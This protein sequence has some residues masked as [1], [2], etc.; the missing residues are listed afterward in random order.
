MAEGRPPEVVGVGAGSG[1]LFVKHLM[2]WAVFAV[3]ACTFVMVTGGVAPAGATALA[4][5]G[6]TD[7]PVVN[8][9]RIPA[10]LPPHTRHIRG[11]TNVSATNWSGYA[12]VSSTPGT[13]TAVTD[14]F[15][16]P[17]VVPPASGKQYVADW[18]G[19][20]GYSDTTLVQTGIQAFVQ[21]RKHHSTVSYDAWT[22]Y[23]PKPEDPL[24]LV[25]SAGDTVTATVQETSADSWL[26][27]VDDVTTGNSAQRPVLSYHS[28]GESAE[29][30]NE[31]PCIKA[32]CLPRDLAHLA[33]TQSPVTFGP[34]FYSTAPPGPGPIV[35]PLALLQPTGSL[36]LVDIVMTNNQEY[37]VH[38]H[39]LGALVDGRRLRRGRRGRPPDASVHLIAVR[40][41]H[42][43]AGVSAGQKQF[44]TGGISRKEAR[45]GGPG[46]SSSCR[47]SMEPWSGP[48]VRAC[49]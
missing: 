11:T 20:G 35:D 6:P 8:G 16:V 31:R 7:V 25:I 19:I 33:Q 4:S 17:T 22:E 23:L 37:G 32:P 21:T 5:G 10:S 43:V 14:T 15:V 48:P 42:P 44:G 38:R 39:A 2:R 29:A 40:R 27:Q 45:G 49:G 30:I 12:E 28:S 47:L 9:A 18:V 24:S 46:P 26:M 41:A 1:G 34:G 13:F 3:A 36:T